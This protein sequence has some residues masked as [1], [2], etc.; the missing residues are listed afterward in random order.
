MRASLYTHNSSILDWD[1]R[2]QE[3]PR[4]ELRGPTPDG[5][6]VP[7]LEFKTFFFTSL[8]P[9]R[10]SVVW[11]AASSLN[12]YNFLSLSATFCVHAFLVKPLGGAALLL[13]KLTPAS[14]LPPTLCVPRR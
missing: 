11:R 13:C 14:C 7:E 4:S 9:D 8:P 5:V 10:F 3:A 2:I 1:P 12:L 6:Q